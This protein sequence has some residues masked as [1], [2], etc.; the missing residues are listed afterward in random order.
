LCID[1]DVPRVEEA[2]AERGL[3]MPTRGPSI[4]HAAGPGWSPIIK[5]MLAKSG[6]FPTDT[7]K[8][9][10][11]RKLD[12]WRLIAVRDED[13]VTC[14]TRTGKVMGSLPYINE[15]LMVLPV[16][17]ILDGEILDLA[18]NDGEEWNRTQK[19]CSRDRAHVPTPDDPALTYVGVDILENE[20]RNMRQCSQSHRTTTVGEVLQALG[21]THIEQI[22][23]T[24]VSENLYQIL[25]EQGAEGVVLKKV[26]GTYLDAKRSPDWLKIKP[27]LECDATVTGTYPASAGSK[28][29]GSHVGGITFKLE[30]GVEGRASGMND[31]DRKNLF[32]KPGDYIGLVVELHYGGVGDDGALRFPRFKRFRD[33]ADKYSL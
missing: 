13:G 22:N 4:N 19:L 7:S 18:A 16:G 32:T 5:P 9:V 15:A 2:M 20:G 3:K 24:P 25:V 33:A 6:K 11:E 10:M 28:Y 27:I 30:N 1:A 23:Q 17:T 14:Y 29:E 12:G 21:N 26:D 8:W 31:E